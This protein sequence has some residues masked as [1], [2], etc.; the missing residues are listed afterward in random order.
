[1][2]FWRLF[3]GFLAAFWWV[4]GGFSVAVCW[5]FVIILPRKNLTNTPAATPLKKYEDSSVEF[6]RI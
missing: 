3:G 5:L 2:G 6:A 4:F 1:M